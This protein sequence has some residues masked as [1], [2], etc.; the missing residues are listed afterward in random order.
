MREAPDLHN[1]LSWKLAHAYATAITSADEP[2]MRRS[3]ESEVTGAHKPAMR[4]GSG[5]L[6]C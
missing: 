2:E 3:F 6:W 1:R 4:A 5:A